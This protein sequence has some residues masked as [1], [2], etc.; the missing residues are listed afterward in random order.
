M[1]KKVEKHAV[2]SANAQ[3]KKF[4]VTAKGK[5]VVKDLPSSSDRKLKQK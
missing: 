4:A 2:D 3:P 1:A 5:K